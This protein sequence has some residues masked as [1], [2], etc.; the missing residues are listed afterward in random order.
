MKNYSQ[1]DEQTYILNYFGDYKGTFIDIGC[2]DGVTLSNT[3][4]LRQ[5]GWKGVYVD[6]SPA[7]F[8]KLKW[9]IPNDGNVWLFNFAFA[10]YDG[11]IILNESQHL[12]GS[13]DIALV[14]T[15][16][17]HEKARFEKYVGYHQVEVNCV[18]WRT[19]KKNFNLDFD[20][21][22]LD[23]E[24]SEMSV[25]PHMDLTQTKMICIEFN[26]NQKLKEQYEQYLHGF[27]LIYTSAENLI[28][29]RL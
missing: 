23:I 21:V 16:H 12:L 5:L 8:E 17:T 20:F 19:F 25:L 18:T 3:Y 6:A 24:G 9:H 10:D 14:S 11:K 13:H 22:S 2:N 28:Y 1:N 7:A 29:I 4:A 26:G 15:V 27:K